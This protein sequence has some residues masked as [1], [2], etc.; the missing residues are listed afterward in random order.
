M[1][2]N[3]MARLA[4]EKPYPWTVI[5]LERRDEYMNAL[6]AVSVSK[7]IKPFAVFVGSLLGLENGKK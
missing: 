1:A 7:I 4:K 3:H 5:P 6:E 2:R